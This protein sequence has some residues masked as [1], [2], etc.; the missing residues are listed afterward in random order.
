MQNQNQC[1]YAICYMISVHR[2]L[3][4]IQYLCSIMV[5]Q[6]YSG[7]IKIT[8]TQRKLLCEDGG[9]GLYN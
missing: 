1:I 7:R 9:G 8:R 5:L 3:F 4:N 6:I 2:L